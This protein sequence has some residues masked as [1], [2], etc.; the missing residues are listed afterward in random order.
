MSSMNMPPD[1][2]ARIRALPGNSTCADCNNVNPQWASVSYGTLVCLECSGQ[3]RALGVHLSFVR[4]IQM[5]SWSQKQIAA[6]EKSGGNASLVKYFSSKG[7]EKGM[8]IAK[9]YNTPQAAYL[10]ERL[11]RWLD[12]KTEPPPDPGRYDPATGGGEAQGAEP[13]PGETTDQYNARQARLREAARER[14]RA[15]FGEGG[16]SGL[17]SCGSQPE[18]TGVDFGGIGGGALSAVGGAVGGAA[19]FLKSN[20][21]DNPSIGSTIGGAVGGVTRIASGGWNSLRQTVTDGDLIDSLKRNATLQEGSVTS[22][23]LDWTK[24]AVGGL[25]DKGRTSVGNASVGSMQSFGSDDRSFQAPSTRKSGN[26]SRRASEIS[27]DKFNFDDNW[28]GDEPVQASPPP[29]PSKTDMDKM[30]KDLGMQ[31]NSSKPETV[32]RGNS[33][34]NVNAEAEIMAIKKMSLTAEPSPTAAKKKEP[35]KLASSDDFFASFGM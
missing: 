8:Q 4:S 22:S 2:Q 31:L 32:S 12:G 1:V 9:K 35:A 14:L 15:K 21:L 11:S 17:G 5:D 3:H 20:V 16:M 19:S 24:G 23:T 30:A 29:A 33:S 7:I 18:N 34:K 25:I 10:R 13:L 27:D 28:G 6:M 26:M